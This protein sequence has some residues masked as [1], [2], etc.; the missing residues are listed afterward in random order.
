MTHCEDAAGNQVACESAD[1]V[2]TITVGPSYSHWAE[3]FA[4][5]YYVMLRGALERFGLYPQGEKIVPAVSRK[6]TKQRGG[7]LWVLN[8]FNPVFRS[9]L[10]VPADPYPTRPET[11][12]PDNATAVNDPA[13]TND[14]MW[15]DAKLSIAWRVNPPDMQEGVKAVGPAVH[16]G[17]Y[18]T[19][20]N[21][22]VT[23]RIPYRFFAAF[24]KEVKPYIYNHVT[25]LWDALTVERAFGGM[26]EF[27]TQV[28][29]LFRAGCSE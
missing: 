8:P 16:F 3:E 15:E 11:F 4:T 21:R 12:A 18:R 9:S 24:G 27:K 22:D 19:V 14:C 28:L 17:P 25:G 2:V 20:F 13:D 23:V 5:A 1:A 29:G 6:I 7:K 10:A 26:V